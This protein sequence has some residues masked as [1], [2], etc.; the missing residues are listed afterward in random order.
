MQTSPI[1][2][3]Q[4]SGAREPVLLLSLDGSGE[5]GSWLLVD[6]GSVIDRGEAHGGIPAEQSR[7]IVSVPG[8]QVA[9]HW[10]DL[11]EGLTRP[12][13]AAAARLVLADRAAEPVDL[14]HLAV[15]RS[16]AGRTP[17]ALVSSEVMESWL[18]GLSAAGIEAEAIVPSPMML[19]P[20]A[21]GLVAWDRGGTRDYRGIGIAFSAEPEIGALIAGE[22]PLELLAPLDWER[23]AADSTATPTLNL[24]QGK[25]ARKTPLFA[26]RDF[27]RAFILLVVLCLAM[28][29]VQVARTASFNISADRLI[30]EK[31]RMLDAAGRRAGQGRFTDLSAAISDALRTFPG[32]EMVSIEYRRGT[33]ASVTMSADDPTMIAQV[34]ARLR[35]TGFETSATESGGAGGR[36]AARLEIRPR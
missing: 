13:A 28:L 20:P 21:S 12:Q 35:E 34:A 36:P 1:D 33:G 30:A 29:A 6:G 7:M 14:L 9:I 22:A 24:L 32:V 16:E 27:R 4:D 31:S 8:E 18:D 25:Y 2:S 15:G 23:A 26:G 19:P 10:V 17:V 11:P 3:P 5:L